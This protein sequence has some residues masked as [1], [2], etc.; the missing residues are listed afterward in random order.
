MNMKILC[1]SVI[2]LLN[3]NTWNDIVFNRKL[4]NITC[5]Y[6][7]LSLYFH[8]WETDE[9]FYIVIFY[10]LFITYFRIKITNYKHRLFSDH[11][12]INT[13]NNKLVVLHEKLSCCMF[14]KLWQ[15]IGHLFIFEST[16]YG[17][18]FSYST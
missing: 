8:F 9:H 18:T 1:V 7:G 14:V 13:N 16:Q 6:I 17:F 2:V 4:K 3:I 15:H 5:L 10:I 12:N 11:S